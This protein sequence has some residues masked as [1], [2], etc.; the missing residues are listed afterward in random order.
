[1][2]FTILTS[3]PFSTIQDYGRLGYQH[4]G[5]PVSGALDREALAIGNHLLGNQLGAAAIEICFGGFSAQAS[6]AS[7]VTLTGS[8]SAIL[9][10]Q[11]KTGNMT[12]Y[13]AGDII[14]ICPDDIITIPPFGD[15]LSCLLCLSGGV[16]VPQLY[17][18][19][20][21]TVSAKIGGHEGRILAPGDRLGLGAFGDA[22][23]HDLPA[24]RSNA[25]EIR[26]FFTKPDQVRLLPGPQ[27]F[28]FTPQA[29]ARLL[30]KPYQISPQT[31]RMGMR[32]KGPALAH[33][34]PADILSDGM[35]RGVLQVPADGQPIIAM[36]DHATMGGY[37]KIATVISADLSGLG[38]LRPHDEISFAFVSAK[39]AK[40]AAKT[41][42]DALMRLLQR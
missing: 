29:L 23:H 34:G 4:L 35:A 19:R 9:E 7:F 15:S 31:S 39:Q 33:K 40:I 16:D 6:Q 27:D 10:H 42:Q 12:R 5:V 18:S 24:L 38:R 2:S 26:Q 32:L 28:W 22:S 3:G 8:A 11:D 1:M 21:T 25:E 41:R 17:G 14:A 37:A 13:Q 30:Q 20:A 36:A